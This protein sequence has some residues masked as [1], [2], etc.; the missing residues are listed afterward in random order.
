MTSRWLPMIVAALVVIAPSVFTSI[1]SAQTPPD[2]G[3]LV[4]SGRP[5]SDITG[6]GGQVAYT[7]SVKD[8]SSTSATGLQVTITL[9]NNVTF[10]RCTSSVVPLSCTHSSGIVT[11]LY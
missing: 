9:P 8:D 10:V 11:A 7:V 5:A 1:S 4:V 2:R 6:S 3:N